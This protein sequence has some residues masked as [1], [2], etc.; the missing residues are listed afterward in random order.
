MEMH[1]DPEQG[2]TSIHPD[3][4]GQFKWSFWVGFLETE[5]AFI[6]HSGRRNGT[7]FLVLAKRGLSSPSEVPRLREMLNLKT[8]GEMPKA[9]T[10]NRG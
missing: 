6:L 10:R 7:P 5:R 8:G 9:W 3:S 2:V 1:V 4:T